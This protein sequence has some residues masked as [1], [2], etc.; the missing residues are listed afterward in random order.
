MPRSPTS[1]EDE[2]AQ[3][4]SDYSA[5]S[6]SDSS[7]EDSVYGTIRAATSG[8]TATTQA[9][10]SKDHTLVIRILIH[11]LQQT[12]GEP[13]GSSPPFCAHP[14][15]ALSTSQKFHLVHSFHPKLLYFLEQGPLY[16]H[17]PPPWLYYCCCLSLPVP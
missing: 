13:W 11:D 15:H 12:V 8:K 4:F 6:E 16:P 5:G 10:E 1:S 2:M 3:S 14:P 9:A 7:K 17:S